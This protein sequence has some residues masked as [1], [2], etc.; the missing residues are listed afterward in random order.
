M[1]SSSRCLLA[2]VP[3]GSSAVVCPFSMFNAEE[4]WL[5]LVCSFY[6]LFLVIFVFS[7]FGCVC[8]CTCL[9]SRGVCAL[10]FFSV[11]FSGSVT[12]V[13]SLM[14]IFTWHCFFFFLLVIHP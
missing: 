6:L 4:L 1:Q 9:P 13:Q 11:V 5:W 3:C 2:A 7:P 14:V 8:V 12:E 10:H